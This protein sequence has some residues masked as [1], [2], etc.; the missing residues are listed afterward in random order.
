MHHSIK[1]SQKEQT[2]AEALFIKALVD[3]S[4]FANDFS[5]N[6]QIW[7]KYVYELH[8]KFQPFKFC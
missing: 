8:L 6:L 5:G 4:F 2:N 1:S 3:V 7:E